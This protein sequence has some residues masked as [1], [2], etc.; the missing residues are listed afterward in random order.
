MWEGP[1]RRETEAEEGSLR[2]R[3]NRRAVQCRVGMDSFLVPT[4]L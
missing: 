2:G 3:G 1:P 4:V